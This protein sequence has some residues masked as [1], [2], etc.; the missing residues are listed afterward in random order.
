[1]GARYVV[2]LSDAERTQLE[3]LMRGGECGV[4]KLK[5]AQILLAA[6]RG[7][8]VGGM[9]GSVGVGTS[10]VYRTTRRLVEEGLEAALSESSREGVCRK[11]SV[12][13]EALL[14]AIACSKAPA[15]RSR[16]TLELLADELVMRTEHEE[17]SRETVRRRLGEQRLKPWQKKMWCIPAVD[18]E[19]VARME[20]VLELYTRAP[21][22]GQAVVCFD[23]TPYQLIDEKRV[24]W[25]MEPGKPERIDY[26]YRRRGSANLFVFLDAHRPWRH[27][28]V[29][30]RKTAIDFAHCMHDLSQVHY[31]DADKV[32]VVLD[33][34]SAHKP[35]AVYEVFEPERARE[36]L[37]RLEFHFVPKHASWLN[38]V[39]IEIGVLMRQC[40]DR[41]IG[42]WE[43]L[44]SEIAHWEHR[45]NAEGARVKWL[46]DVERARHKLGRV[47]PRPL[48]STVANAA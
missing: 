37:R 27:V 41:R 18:A 5:R 33:N 48:R 30:E 44:R 40:L 8:S 12:R 31:R 19:Y 25:P 1:M 4:R 14:V 34:F 26:E 9:A 45:R 21:E 17:L 32:H 20:E 38:M 42:D 46:F 3:R 36:V 43:R 2:E 11:L 28:E 23:E 29:S 16:W 24:S 22:A 47:Y 6:E 10:T 7:E 13:E 39:E 35:S 15:G